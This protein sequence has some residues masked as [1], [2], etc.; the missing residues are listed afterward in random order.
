MTKHSPAAWDAGLYDD[1]HAFV[2]KHGEALVELLRPVAGERILDVGCGTGHLT[3]RLAEA[4]ADVV[5]LD[6]SAVMLEQARAAYPHLEFVLG[7]ARAFSFGRPFDAVFS[8]AA[9]HWVRE[10]G[11]VARCVR[12]CLRP[13][14]RFVAELGGRGNVAAIVAA[15]RQAAQRLGIDLELPGWY[16]PGVAEYAGLLEGA[17]LEVRF[18]VLFDRPTPLEGPDGLRAWVRMFAATTLAA[19]GAGRHEE[20]LGALEEAGRPAL[21][22]DGGWHADYRRLRVVAVR[23]E[24]RLTTP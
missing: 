1:R 2:W 9:L 22:H 3:A 5:G 20:F 24:G 18:A 10:A 12:A 16:F 7:D 23:D 14:G 13:G 21:F 11:A 4:G 6:S 8:N 17:G 19:V 15:L